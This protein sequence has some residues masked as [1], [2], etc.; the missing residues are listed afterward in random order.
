MA[1][2][3]FVASLTSFSVLSVRGD[4]RIAWLQGQISNDVYRSGT[5]HAF[6][7]DSTGKIEA[8]VHAVDDGSTIRIVVDASRAEGLATSLDRRIVMEDVSVVLERDV[9]VVAMYSDESTPDG[10]LLDAPS[11]QTRR[12]GCPG[13]EWIVASSVIESSLYSLVAS[14]ATRASEGDLDAMRIE[15]GRPRF[16]VDFDASL[17]HETGLLKST[18][19]FSKGCYVGQE[20]V[21]MIE[22]RGKPPRRMVTIRASA[23]LVAPFELARADGTVVGRC[24]SFRNGVGIALVKRAD[25]EPGSTLQA[26]G[27]AVAVVSL[28]DALPPP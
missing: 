12:F 28:V 18:V 2:R 9:G 4:D 11:V 8:E 26:N 20:P 10:S 19:S 27:S 23:V 16:G 1:A 13:R 22:H 24:A 25:S 7:L 17:P 6:R 14:G 5:V 15:L 3:R 21:V